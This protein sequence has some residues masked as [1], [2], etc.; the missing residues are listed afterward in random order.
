MPNYKPN[1]KKPLASKQDLQNRT[2]Y[3][4]SHK[5][6]DVDY[7]DATLLRQFI[8]GYAKIVKRRITKTCAKHQRK[9][10]RAVKRA[11]IASLLPFVIE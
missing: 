2:C 5:L 4:C 7:K 8:S 3:L 6:E 11:R 1:F 9:V 10:S